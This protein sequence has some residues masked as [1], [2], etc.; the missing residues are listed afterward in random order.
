MTGK[1]IWMRLVEN[2]GLRGLR[3]HPLQQ[4]EIRR[5]ATPA[6]LDRAIVFNLPRHQDVNALTR[7]A[8]H[9]RPTLLIFADAG[10]DD[11][12]AKVASPPEQVG[13]EGSFL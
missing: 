7:R 4:L 12:L 11:H 13:V 2:V 1:D 3:S 10:F 9:W 6:S 5:Q 8:P